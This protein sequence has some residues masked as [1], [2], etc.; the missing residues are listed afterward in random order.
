MI[1]VSSFKSWSTHGL[2][3]VFDAV[4]SLPEEPEVV[5]GFRD[6]TSMKPITRHRISARMGVRRDSRAMVAELNTIF[7]VPQVSAG[8]TLQQ[9]L[10]VCGVGQSVIKK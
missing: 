9:S 2:K 7:R 5:S 1:S 10:T 8:L 3:F 6:F 4:L